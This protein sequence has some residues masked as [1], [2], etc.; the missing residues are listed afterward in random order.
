MAQNG[1]LES[2]E[3]VGKVGRSE[4]ADLIRSPIGDD[5][6]GF[7]DGEWLTSTG[8]RVKFSEDWVLFAAAPFWGAK[9]N[10]ANDP[11]VFR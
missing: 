6:A 1:R 3:I 10:A 7:V 11:D 5:S 4:S 2:V 8:I 9:K